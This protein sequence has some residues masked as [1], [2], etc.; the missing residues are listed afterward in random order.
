V[1]T[2]FDVY[3]N[4][5]LGVVTMALLVG[6]YFYIHTLK[7]QIVDLKSSLKDSYVELANEKL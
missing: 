4:L 5:I 1:F 6:L 2:Q 7:T 3:K